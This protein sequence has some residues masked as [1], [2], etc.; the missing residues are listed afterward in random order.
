MM[1]N[2]HQS[3]NELLDRVDTAPDLSRLRGTFEGRSLL[4]TGAGG[5]IGAELSETLLQ[6]HPRKLVLLELSED[7]LY[8]VSMR[9]G[10]VAA[11][12]SRTPEIVP[13]IGSVCDERLL[14]HLFSHSRPAIIFHAAAFKHVPLMEQNRFAVMANNSVGTHT[15][16][17]A[18]L[19]GGAGQLI[20]ISTDKAVNPTSIMGASKRI[21]EVILLSLSTPET[22]MTSVR[23]CN[24]LG[25]RGSVMPLFKEQI[26][27]GGPV[28]VTHPEVRRYFLTIKEAVHRILTGA[29]LDIP[30]RILVPEMGESIRLIDLARALIARHGEETAIVYTGLRP[31]DRLDEEL[32]SAEEQRGA[33]TQ[34][35]FRMV[36][37]PE[38]SPAELAAK[39]DELE[40]ATQMFDEA[41]LMQSLHELVPEYNPAVEVV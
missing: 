21:A 27:R 3:M 25:S 19:R 14:D 17:S 9:L 5:S 39:I 16:A 35:E 1:A 28:T 41:L 10:E 29:A 7:A 8:R 37:G 13:I 31:G 23:L 12:M 38:I 18:A 33:R 4:I 11:S 2:S 30:G 20:L 34:G 36:S 40:H 32:I 6:M 15:L 24:V 22:H 26:G